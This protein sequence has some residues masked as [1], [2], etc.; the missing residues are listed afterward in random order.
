MT[1][2]V[3][4]CEFTTSDRGIHTLFGDIFDLEVRIVNTDHFSKV[5]LLRGDEDLAVI[6]I[7]R[8]SFV[9]V[10]QNN[11]IHILRHNAEEKGHALRSHVV[12]KNLS[13]RFIDREFG[14]GFCIITVADRR[15][16]AIIFETKTVISRR[17]RPVP[18]AFFVG[19]PENVITMSLGYS[20]HGLEWF[21]DSDTHEER[22]MRIGFRE[23][24]TVED[25]FDI[26]LNGEYTKK[27]E[28]IKD[29]F[30]PDD[31]DEY[32]VMRSFGDFFYFTSRDGRFVFT[33]QKN[34]C[35][36]AINAVYDVIDNI[37]TGGI[38]W[39]ERALAFVTELRKAGK[40]ADAQKNVL[41]LCI[42][43]LNS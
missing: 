6:P 11:W 26:Y 23:P 10:T 41:K 19:Y 5:T 28:I 40:S 4:A 43:L 22:N 14:P 7:N 39:H 16:F 2:Q 9:T 30:G 13:M 35:F 20:P 38:M 3:Q 31:P 42:E 21:F 18:N 36:L 37:S 24:L 32:L 17:L 29:M 27:F 34:A 12:I 33:T 15:R 8:P 1:S 25:I